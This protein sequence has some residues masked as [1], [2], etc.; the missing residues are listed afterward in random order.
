ILKYFED[1]GSAHY[2][3]ECFVFDQRTGVDPSLH[4]SGTAQC[5]HCQAPL[6]PEEQQDPRYQ[7]GHRCPHCYIPPDEER[8][9]ALVARQRRLEQVATPLPGSIPYDN[10]RPI[11]VPAALHGATLFPFL[12]QLLPHVEDARW[13][14]LYTDGLLV[15]DAGAPVPLD[16]PLAAGQRVLHREPATR[17][18]D[19]AHQIKLLHEDEALI[20]VEKPAP[21]PMHPGGRY[22]RN[23]LQY[24]LQQAFHPCKP[25][26]AHRL[27]ANTSG[28]VV[29]TKTRHFAGRLQPAFARGEVEKH[30][31]AR[32]HGH[33]PTDAFDGSAR[34]R[35]E[36]ST[37]AIRGVDETHGQE[38]L[39]RFRVL[40]RFAD[41]TSL[42]SAQPITGRTNQIRIHL[43]HLGFPIVGDPSYLPDGKTGETQTL[44]LGAP[45]M[46]L[47]ASTLTFPHPSSGIPVSFSAADPT[48]IRP[49]EEKDSPP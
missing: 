49:E 22:N 26:P 45:P 9:A 39:T 8:A 38:A 23:T 31:L 35:T 5:Y 21:L 29:F 30:Y 41:G 46:C 12:T 32:V 15:N 27:D 36:L 44:P 24:L 25:R 48:W 4:E 14:Q 11:T 7:P 10:V 40:E 6:T 18:P 16:Q 28:V 19:V 13:E 1:C 42:L 43:W 33:P 3:G 17:E 34:I 2:D 20:V 47:H 37:A